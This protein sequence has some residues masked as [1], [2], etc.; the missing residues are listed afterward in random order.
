[1]PRPPTA[2]IASE[3]RAALNYIVDLHTK[4]RKDVWA[5]H[6]AERS[7]LRRSVARHA[8]KHGAADAV[9][10]AEALRAVPSKG[11]SARFSD[12]EAQALREAS[13]NWLKSERYSLL[14]AF[15]QQVRRVQTEWSD[16][17]QQLRDV[18]HLDGPQRALAASARAGCKF[19]DQR[20]WPRE[21]SR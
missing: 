17:V 14:T 20:M 9:A 1:M 4:Q 12:A 10:G 16:H 3:C 6:A 7:K 13:A 2:Q 21:T 11:S 18:R 15:R 19:A 8:A 5:R